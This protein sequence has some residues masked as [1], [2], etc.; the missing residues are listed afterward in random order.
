M[1]A[2][3]VAAVLVPDLESIA[4][5]HGETVAADAAAVRE[6]ARAEVERLNRSLPPYKKI[7]DFRIRSEEF[8]KTSSRKIKRYLYKTWAEATGA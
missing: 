7:S 8:E 6:L 5:D 1:A 4:A 2:E 3:A